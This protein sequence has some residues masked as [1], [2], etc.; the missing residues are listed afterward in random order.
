MDVSVSMAAV[1]FA[2]INS[3]TNTHPSLLNVILQQHSFPLRVHN[4]QPRSSRFQ[5]VHT[6]RSNS[7][8][9][10]LLDDALNQMGLSYHYSLSA[11]ANTTA[12]ELAVFLGTVEGDAKLLGFDP[13][14]VVNGSFDTPDRRSFARRVAR[15]RIIKDSNL[16]GELDLPREVCWSHYPDSGECRLA[17]TY[18]VVLVLADE[19]GLESVFGFFRFPEQ[20]RDRAGRVL[21][22][23]PNANDW[24]SGTF[25]DSPDPRYRAIIRRFRDAG[26]VSSERDE[27]RPAENC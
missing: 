21:A 17:P 26:Y 2:G 4:R 16:R 1:R 24:A 6:F 18:G 15:G 7:E 5:A 8:T 3:T 11:S 9:T 12:S 14:I 19:R 10:A 20:I 23:V 22:D 13:T 27:F 25:I